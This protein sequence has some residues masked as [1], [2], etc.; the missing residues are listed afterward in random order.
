MR[1]NNGNKIITEDDIILSDGSSTLSERLSSQQSDIN[2]LKSNLKWIYKYGGV[3]SGTGG[4]GSPIQSFSIYATL[5]NIQLKDQSIVLNGEG[6]YQLYIKINNPNGASFNVQYSYTTRSSTGNTITQ[7]QTQILSIDNNYTFQTQISLNNNDL[8]TIIASDGNSTQQIS[9]NYV[10]SAY[11]FTPSLV[12]DN[13]N[14]LQNE[15]FVSNAQSNGINIKLDYTISV[16]ADTQYTY[17]FQDKQQSGTIT[18]KN[19]SILFPISKDLFL[20]ENAG[21]YSATIQINIIPENQ[22]PVTLNYQVSFNLIPNNLY[23][24]VTPQ[25][26]TIYKQETDDPY[27]FSAGYITFNYRIYEG[28]NQNRQYTVQIELNGSQV[29]S[30]VVTERQQN[31]FR[32]FTIQ[33]G[34][35]TLKVTVSRTESRSWTYYFYVA[36]TSINLDW[37]DNPSEWTQYYYRLNETTDN[38]SQYKGQLY[39]EQTMNSNPISISGIQPPNIS[40]DVIINTHVAVG[41][42]Y[43]A[44]NGDNSNILQFF[45]S[46]VGSTSVLDI[47]QESITRSGTTQALY[48]KKQDNCDKDEVEY[49]HLIQIYSQYVK[50]IGNEFYYEIS[51][52]IDGVLEAV[53]PQI[54]NSPLL[55]TSLAI[56]PTNCYINL[57]EVDY[58]QGQLGNNCD[59]EVYKYY[60][61]YKNEILRLDVADELQLTEYLPNYSVGLDGRVTVD[62][63]TIN[64]VANYIDTPTLVM[65]YEDSGQFSDFMGS[66][67]ANYGEDGSQPGADMNFPVTLQWSPG[68]NGLSDISFPSGYETAQYRAALQGSSTKLYRVKNFTLALENTDDSEQADVFLYSPNFSNDDTSTFLP[69]TEF[70]LKAD[71]VD[72]SH[73]NNTSC[74]KF[75]NTVCRKFS[76]DIVENG[77][78]R[79]YIRNCLEGFPMLLYLCVVK[80]DSPSGEKTQTYYYLGIYNFN[81][82]RSSYYNLGYKDLTVFGD[83]NNPLLQNAGDS[84]TFFKINQS[85]NTLRQGLGV[86]EIQGGSNYFDFSQYD[87]SILFQ[88]ILSG[89]QIDNTYMF[90][91][92]VFGS[93]STE[94]NL[95]SEIQSLVQKVALAGGYL[96]DY[97]KKNRGSYA[98]GYRAEKKDGGGHYTGESLN[99]VPDYTHQYERVLS[100]T[101]TWEYHEKQTISPGTINNLQELIIPDPDT[102]RLAALNFQSLAEYY[103]ICMVLGLVDSVQKNLNIKTWN[104]QTWYL[105]FYD[106]DTCLGIN[107]QGSD[108]NYFAFSDYWNS[109]KTTQSGI[110]YPTDAIIYRDFSP[111]SMGENGYDIPSSYLFAVAKYAKLIFSSTTEDYSA[112]MSVYPQELYAKWRS[113]AINQDTNEGILRNADY[114]VNNFFSNNLGSINPNLVSYNYRSKYLSLGSSAANVSW[115]STDYNKFNGTRV[116]KVREWLNGRLHILDVYFNLNTTIINPISYLDSDGTWKPLQVGGANVSDIIYSSQYSLSTNDDI[117]ILHDIFSEG[118]SSAGVQLSG[119]VNIRIKCP[120]YSPLQIYNANNTIRKNYILGGDNYQQIS[121]QTTGVQG[122][123]LG[124][125]QAWTY[126]EN[127][128]WLSTSTL[129]INSDNLQNITGT[130]GSFSGI[131]LDTPNLQTLELTSPNYSGTLSISGS[132]SFPNIDSVNISR[133]NLNLSISNVGVTYI[134]A[135]NISNPQGEISIS[136][137]ESLKT[138][139]CTNSTLSHL[140]I[141]GLRGNLKNFTLSNTNI[142]TIELMC[143]EE[144]GTLTISDDKSVEFI[145]VSGFETVIIN[146]CPKLQQVH[147][148]ISDIGL[149]S[150][151]VSECHNDTM[152]ITSTTREEAGVVDLSTL[153]SLEQLSLRDTYGIT[154]LYLP[155]NVTLVQE[156]LYNLYNLTSIDGNNIIICGSGVFNQCNEYN[157]RTKSGSY[158]DLHVGSEVT[159]INKLFRKSRSV[160]NI[161]RDDV[162]HFIETAIEQ[163]NS[164]T[165]ISYIFYNNHGI[166]YGLDEFKED[167]TQQ[168]GNYIDLTKFSKVTNAVGAFG[169]CQISVYCKEMWNLGSSNGVDLYFFCEPSSKDVN[170]IYVTTDTLQNVISKVTRIFGTYQ[171]QRLSMTFI[172]SDTGNITTSEIKIKDFFNPSGQ[173]PI[174]L[175]TLSRFYL[176]TTQTFDFTATFNSAWVSLETLEEFMY[177]TNRK[178]YGLDKLLLQLP[179][180]KN[181]NSVFRQSTL[182]ERVNLYTFLNWQYLLDNNGQFIVCGSDQYSQGAFTINKYINYN[183]YNTLCNMI[184]NSSIT[185]ISFLFA[186]CYIVG[187]QGDFTFGNGDVVNSTIQKIQGLYKD[188]KLVT[189]LDSQQTGYMALSPT[190]F[191][192]M[193]GITDVRY[194]FYGCDFNKPIPF[195]FFNKR[196]LDQTVQRDVFIKIRDNNYV[197]GTLYSYTYRP[198][199]YAF[200]RVFMNSTWSSGNNQYDPSLYTIE[201][202]RVEY[203]DNQTEYNTY[204][205]RVAI[206][207]EGEEGPQYQYIEHTIEQPTEITDTEDLTGYYIQ[208]VNIGNYTWQNPS[209]S[210]D[211]NK[212]CIPP[213]FFYGAATSIPIDGN[214]GVQTYD[215]AF[216]CSTPLVGIIPE[217]IFSKNKTGSVAGVFKGQVIIPRLINTIS[218]ASTTTNIYTHFPPNYSTNTNLDNAFNIEPIVP[219]NSTI[220]SS[221]VINKVYVILTDTIP[222]NVSSMQRA[223]EFSTQNNTYW[224]GQQRNSDC[225]ISYIG[226]KEGQEGF[227]ITIFKDLNMD[228]LLYGDLQAISYGQLFNTGFDAKD[229]KFATQS[230][231]Y[232]MYYTVRQL[233]AQIILPKATGNVQRLCYFTTARYTVQASQITDLASS[234]QYYQ[235]I[236]NIE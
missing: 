194:A 141:Q 51:L 136:Q 137:C 150:L 35:N 100:S 4:G 200:A 69:E 70:T 164:I 21:Y 2:Q 31:Q 170:T 14:T 185:D 98:D 89:Q 148:N 6:N 106:M 127:I 192:N 25:N 26:G 193:I 12:D 50:S 18:D 116:N 105:A 167:A 7:S 173:A 78:Y 77:Y 71:V 20:E 120:E 90:G 174:K 232:V 213:D 152:M 22:D 110:D 33:S 139:T 233:S 121:F 228:Y 197:P 86:A 206:P 61:K 103:T 48:I 155:D 166:I 140:N 45:N 198:E 39:I 24:L 201:R 147:I 27:E 81:L 57:L 5:N 83:R 107:N 199:I 74:G 32:V 180:L 114:F 23:M 97:I 104:G 37:F 67:E 204:Y 72:S 142:T 124:G 161:T 80:A 118:N 36:E 60:L 9:C 169:L 179:K 52:Y 205:T 75:V 184:L 3:G 227:D 122:V 165:D 131:Q 220:G 149:K 15:I 175:T 76:T 19:N 117:V 177:L 218:S 58:K 88:Q 43:N 79:N 38:F 236:F 99:Q 126:L 65:T 171:A 225:H 125:S 135:S 115:I 109:S 93:N 101:G 82:G 53:F 176:N 223:F 108:I 203:G 16:N 66:L 49:Y 182:D 129:T 112:Y 209:A 13:G 91:D 195:N 215:Y 160:D 143:S 55:I 102:Q 178:Y 95:Q 229:M 132:Q 162:K 226:S 217:H 210:G 144:G 34:L 113:N 29:D 219:I 40:G 10:T 134:N 1:L 11:V 138:F 87:N 94:L 153:S 158:T 202:N 189:S 211:T 119:Q 59:Y 85:E 191:K 123:K 42:Q 92:L 187:Y 41:L 159:S 231:T 146:N 130:Q 156:A 151:T 73:S 28:T 47:N 64:N 8:L 183:D 168:K 44:I 46:G 154:E 128:N 234:Q 17:T 133:S 181:L 207:S 63:S 163:D 30:T 157:L 222:T 56:R 208:N 224:I 68:R 54:S 190:F 186:N 188:C 84:F 221:Q 96:F 214:N 196:Q 111:N 172:D 216:N 145:T 62:Y 230:G 212:L 235:E